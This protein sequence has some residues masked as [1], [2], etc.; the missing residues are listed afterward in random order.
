M[1]VAVA[2]DYSTL[3]DI[4][5]EAGHQQQ[6]VKVAVSGTVDGANTDFY[7][8]KLPIVDRT[9]S[10]AVSA[11]DAILYV[12]DVPVTI[13][14]IDAATGRI[15][16]NV[17]P[18]IGTTVKATYDFSSISDT[19]VTAVRLEAIT[20]LK[21]NLEGVIDY[22]VWETGVA[23]E[24]GGVPEDLRMITRLFAAGLIMIRSYGEN[25][26]NELVSKNGYKKL[27]EAKKLMA[28]YLA[29]IMDNAGTT[30]PVTATVVSDGNLFKRDTDLDAS[31]NESD[32]T[33]EFF[34]KDN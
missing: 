32:S 21:R 31:Y 34:H 6:Q 14:S 8:P 26:D 25:V 1:A 7:V 24:A 15:R 9:Y 29:A 10:D 19:R 22:S 28:E 12:D 16:A 23:G 3:Q 17:A 4:R 33:E 27:A 30:T 13:S 18:A 11:G 2:A 20:W 5:E